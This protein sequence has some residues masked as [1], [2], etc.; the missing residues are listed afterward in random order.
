MNKNGIIGLVV[1]VLVVV[2]A[3]FFIQEAD[4]GPLE[5]AAEDIEDAADDLEDSV[6]Q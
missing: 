4:D 2:A 3:I 1:L 6:D 5:N